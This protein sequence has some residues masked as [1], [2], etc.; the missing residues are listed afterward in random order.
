MA[1]VYMSC[2]CMKRGSSHIF[3]VVD[4]KTHVQIEEEKSLLAVSFLIPCGDA[5][6]LIATFVLE[7]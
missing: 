2:T 7:N 3:I 5:W 6:R 1:S 4:R